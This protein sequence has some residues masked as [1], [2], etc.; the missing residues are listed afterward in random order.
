MNDNSVQRSSTDV[1]VSTPVAFFVFNRPEETRKVFEQ[2]ARGKPD[3]LLIVADGPR[4]SHPEDVEKCA[5]VREIVTDVDWSCNLRTNFAERNLGV[6]E[7]FQTGLNWVFE[8]VAEAIVLEDDCLPSLDFFP[9]CEWMLD[10]YRDD[11]RVMNITGTNFLTDWKSD[12]QDYH[13]ST[14]GAIWGWATWERAWE[15]Y[16]PEMERWA[17]PEIRE[18]VADFISDDEQY[19]WRQKMYWRTFRGEIET[20]DFQWGFAR[21]INSGLTIVPSRNLVTN[22]GFNEEATHTDNPELPYANLTA[23]TLSFPLERNAFVSP[24]RKYDQGL[25]KMIAPRSIRVRAKLYKWL[26]KRFHQSWL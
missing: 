3:E 16:D 11:K 5:A 22:I 6:K 17:D 2:I 24:D 21:H 20:W 1:N 10:E 19:Y 9:F 26:P 25:Y 13:F 14:H 15:A 4:Q 8:N 7:R 23:E 12:R 18:R